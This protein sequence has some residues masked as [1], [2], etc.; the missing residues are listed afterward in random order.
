MQRAG[1]PPAAPQAG[2]GLRWDSGSHGFSYRKHKAL[3]LGGHNVELW[4]GQLWRSAASN[5]QR[6]GGEKAMPNTASLA[7]APYSEPEELQRTH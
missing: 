5:P 3:F 2:A 4:K 6:V 7:M 1:L